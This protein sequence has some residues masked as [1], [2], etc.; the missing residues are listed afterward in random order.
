MEGITF[1]WVQEAATEM[2]ERPVQN[3][4]VRGERRKNK[5]ISRFNPLG[6]EED[7]KIYQNLIV[8]INNS[9]F[10]V[11]LFSE[12]Y[13]FFKKTYASLHVHFFRPDKLFYF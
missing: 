11:F 4:Q 7:S 13:Q 2:E 6:Q 12:A 1:H 3:I 5:T 8:E 9:N 10:E